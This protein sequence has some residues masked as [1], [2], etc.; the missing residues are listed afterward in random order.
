MQWKTA[1]FSELTGK[2]LKRTSWD[3]KGGRDEF[4]FHCSDGEVYK[5]YHEQ[6]CCEDVYLEDIC[7]GLASLIGS[8]ITL[9]EE[10]SSSDEPELGKDD[11]SYTWTFYRLATKNGLVTFRW[12]GTSNGYY[13]EEAD[14]AR[15][16]DKKG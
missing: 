10:C 3:N 7:G 1:E 9:A 14:F 16:A 12:Y 15:K 4:F 8:P 6:D 11:G 2:V 5:M 13:S